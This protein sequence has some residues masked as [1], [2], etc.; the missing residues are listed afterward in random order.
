MAHSWAGNPLHQQRC[1]CGR[2]DFSTNGMVTLWNSIV[3]NSPSGSN[4]FSTTIDGGHNI[5]SDGSCTF[6][7]RAVGIT[8]TG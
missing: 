4:C 3:A 7:R 1:S 6:L 8:R 2:R 5:S